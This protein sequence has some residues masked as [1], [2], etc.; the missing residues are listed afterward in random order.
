MK[1][2]TIR[3]AWDTVNPTPDQKRRMRAALESKLAAS[4]QP[5][6]RQEE[7]LPDIRFLDL[8]LPQSP[9]E[10]TEPQKPARKGK[11]S[12]PRYQ[13]SR[14]TKTNWVGTIAATA[15]LLALVTAEIGRAS[16]RER[17]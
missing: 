6:K 15:A 7:E 16:C 5:Q 1:N 4:S 17:V 13:S 10:K 8:T 2:T 14:P 9:A 3:S 11:R 12:A